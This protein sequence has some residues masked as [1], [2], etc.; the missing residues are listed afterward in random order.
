MQKIHPFKCLS[1][2]TAS[3]LL[4]FGMSATPILA[5]ATD[6]GE[7]KQGLP[8]RRISGGVRTGPGS[9]F[10]DFNQSAVAVVPHAPVSKTAAS[11][12]TFW[13][14]LPE[15]TS[16]KTVKFSLFNAAEELIYSTYLAA[17]NEYALSE[18]K[19]PNSAPGLATNENYSWVLSISCND[20]SQTSPVLGL[21]SWV[22]RVD[23]SAELA[24]KIE[25]AS[26]AERIALYQSAELWHE[27]M[28]A[29][30]NLRR[31]QES[32]D[33]SLQSDWT[34]LMQST[35]LA[36]YLASHISESMTA[37]DSLA[38]LPNSSF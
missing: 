12:P 17:S 16:D 35:G 10:T 23:I 9:C 24:A 6:N 13:F 28:T 34:A 25:A 26:P 15:T 36:D 7:V 37:I 19:L 4:S 27:Q 38:Y 3:L 30:A 5:S 14:S 22:Q 2:L 33:T 1:I 11:H 31:R 18:F 32:F 29:L 20:S 21:H 8:G